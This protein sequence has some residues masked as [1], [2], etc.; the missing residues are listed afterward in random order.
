MVKIILKQGKPIS[1][2]TVDGEVKLYPNKEVEMPLN[3]AISLLGDDNLSVVFEKKD[4][5]KIRKLKRSRFSRLEREFGVENNSNRKVLLEKMFPKPKPI[6][7]R[8][9]LFKK[10]KVERPVK[11]PV[12]ATK[13]AL[14]PKV[15][16]AKATQE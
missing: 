11:E 9:D 7:K 4:E 10:S 1:Y 2:L 8:P 15:D 5:V 14:K 3:N 13:P 6:I 16:K 12:K